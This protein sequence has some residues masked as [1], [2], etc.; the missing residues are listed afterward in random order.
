MRPFKVFGVGYIN[1]HPNFVPVKGLQGWCLYSVKVPRKPRAKEE[2]S[3]SFYKC[4]QWLIND[5][6][7]ISMIRPGRMVMISGNWE[8]VT[9]KESNGEYHTYNYIYVEQITFLPGK[10]EEK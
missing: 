5:S 1:S 6:P 7:V 3:F 9:R 10:N 8:P 2:D 4:K